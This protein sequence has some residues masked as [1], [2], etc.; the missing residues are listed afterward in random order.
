M[1]IPTDERQKAG[2]MMS[3]DVWCVIDHVIGTVGYA[4][5][6]SVCGKRAK[7]CVVPIGLDDILEA[8]FR[9]LVHTAGCSRYFKRRATRHINNAKTEIRN[10][11]A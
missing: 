2:E 4:L 9:C 11:L 7:V 6:C 8:E 10:G 5:K 1:L 3:R